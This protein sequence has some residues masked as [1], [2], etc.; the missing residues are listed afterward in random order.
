MKVKLKAILRELSKVYII[1]WI[2]TFLIFFIP[3]DSKYGWKGKLIVA[4]MLAFIWP[5]FAILGIRKL[6]SSNGDIK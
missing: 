6:I 1:G 2:F 3:K 4:S 5:Y